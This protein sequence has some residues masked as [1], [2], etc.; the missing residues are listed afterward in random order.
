MIATLFIAL[1][2]LVALG[3]I[4]YNIASEALMKKSTDNLEGIRKIKRNAIQDYFLERQTDLSAMADTVSLL[5]QEAFDKIH[6]N[7]V[8]SGISD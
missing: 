1:I 8:T 3:V 6:A 4:T 2:P 7:S 5:Y